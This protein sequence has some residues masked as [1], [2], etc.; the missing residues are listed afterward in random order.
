[1]S[2]VMVKK[3][4]R[5]GSPCAKCAQAEEILK[6]RGFLKMIDS[7]VYAIEDDPESEGMKLGRE[8]GID[9]APFFIVRDPSG[10]VRIHTRVFE[11]I[12]KEFEDRNPLPGKD[13]I[14]PEASRTA[15]VRPESGDLS[16][17]VRS[18]DTSLFNAE[19]ADR[20]YSEMDPQSIINDAQTA[21]G[22]GLALAF[23]GAEDVVLIDM[24]MKNNRPFSVF[25]LD[26]GRLHPETYDF[27]DAVRNFYGIGIEIFTPSPHLLEPFLAEKGINSFYQDGHTE[28][29][30]IR[31][32]EPLARALASRRAWAT[33]LR[34]DQSPE[35]RENL[36]YAAV[37]GGQGAGR[38]AP[39]VKINPLL[40][41]SSSQVWDYIRANGVPYNPLHDQ[42]YRSIGCAPCTRA[43]RPGEHER[44][45]R[46]WWEDST[47][48]ECGLH[49]RK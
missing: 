35:T 3:I 44:A 19:L 23:S 36:R 4:L 34:R 2:I 8:F 25:C 46:W 16:D 24:A 39:L 21:F 43:S 29:C 45:A 11:F 13:E 42:G 10:A 6:K 5:D 28:C 41:W 30:G 17:S 20:K 22:S 47:K 26:T 27:I 32:V 14:K 18:S 40:D 9:L 37:E 7:V 12:K 33:G 49:T 31:K 48:R 1:M 15:P 38:A